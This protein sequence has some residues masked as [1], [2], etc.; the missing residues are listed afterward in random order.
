MIGI[1]SSSNQY[2]PFDL[3][4]T[5]EYPTW[6]ALEK[7]NP[8]KALLW[9][10]KHDKAI[11]KGDKMFSEF[12]SHENSYESLAPLS[13][14]FGRIV[15][16]SFGHLRGSDDTENATP[17]VNVRHYHDTEASST[18]EKDLLLKVCEFVNSATSRVKLTISGHNIIN[19]DIPFFIKRCLANKIQVPRVFITFNKKPWEL[20]FLDTGRVWQF[21]SFDGYASLDLVTEILGIESPKTTMGGQYVGKEFWEKQNYDGIA[22]YCDQDVIAVAKVLVELSFNTN[23]EL[24]IK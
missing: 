9:K 1:I 4:T 6:K 15:C 3:E 17:I 16:A 11:Q 22:F 23:K 13:P 12:E 18:S 20:D 24:T 8:R 5:S 10:L 2:L 7:A 19:F 14:E 21:G